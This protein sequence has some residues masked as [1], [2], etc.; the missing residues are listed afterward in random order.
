[1]KLLKLITIIFAVY[2]IRRF[3]QL[4]KAMKTLHEQQQASAQSQNHQQGA[5]KNKQNND[6]IE[7]DFKVVK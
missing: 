1:M 3:I 5:H 4:Y 7:A 2:F 6:I